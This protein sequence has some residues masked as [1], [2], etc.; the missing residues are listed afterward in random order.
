MLL[1]TDTGE[2]TVMEDDD[3]DGAGEATQSGSQEVAAGQGRQ[4]HGRTPIDKGCVS[5]VGGRRQRA[6]AP[7]R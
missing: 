5:G 3:E 4:G 2:D 6:P 1:D 7:K